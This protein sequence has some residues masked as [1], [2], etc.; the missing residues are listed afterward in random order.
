ME[1]GR[2]CTFET[3][4]CQ[5][6]VHQTLCLPCAYDLNSTARSDPRPLDWHTVA[7]QIPGRTDEECRKRWQ[8]EVGGGTNKLAWTT[9]E[10]ERLYDA[11]KEHGTNWARVAPE[12]RTRNGDQCSKR[13]NHAI[14]PG[15]D[16][17]TWTPEEVCAP[18][19]WHF[20]LSDRC[21]RRT[22]FFFKLLLKLVKIGSQSS[23]IIF[24]IGLPWP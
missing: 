1:C 16:H 6:C 22:S 2:G 8:S 19:H 14:G 11:V 18:G 15:L 23:G 20:P 7:A 9:S 3:G 13:W 4:R 21:W 10:D 17:S 12:V 24:P 5:R